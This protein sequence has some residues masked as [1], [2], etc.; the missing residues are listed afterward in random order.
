[1]ACAGGSGKF[2]ANFISLF[3]DARQRLVTANHPPFSSGALSFIKYFSLIA[4]P[5]TS[6]LRRLNALL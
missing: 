4:R 3:A 1:L 5:E 2:A 6:A